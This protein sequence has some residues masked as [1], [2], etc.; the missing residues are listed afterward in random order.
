MKCHYSHKKLV[1]NLEG[2]RYTYGT[3]ERVGKYLG[4]SYSTIYR[5]RKGITEPPEWIKKEYGMVCQKKYVRI[6]IYGIARTPSK[7]KKH[8]KKKTRKGED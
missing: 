1:K 4:F 2:L 3:W 8:K 7:D 5:W 6:V